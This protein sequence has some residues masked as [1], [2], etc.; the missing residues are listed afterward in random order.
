LCGMVVP[1]AVRGVIICVA[2]DCCRTQPSDRIGDVIMA[3]GRMIHAVATAA[4]DPTFQRGELGN[5]LG[6]I[7]QTDAARVDGCQQVNVEIGLRSRRLLVHDAVLAE[8]LAWPLAGIAI[9]D[10]LGDVVGFTEA[11]IFGTDSFG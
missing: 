9:P 3:T 7:Q 6:M 1:G 8:D 5:Q 10:D 11:R 4:S 2:T